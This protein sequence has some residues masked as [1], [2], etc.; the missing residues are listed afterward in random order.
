MVG[1][2]IIL[3]S[4]EIQSSG[5]KF[6]T[7]FINRKRNIRKGFILLWIPFDTYT[8]INLSIQSG[9][10][11]I[12]SIQKVWV[13]SIS[14]LFFP[15]SWTVHQLNK[16]RW[17]IDTNRQNRSSLEWGFSE[18]GTVLD[19]EQIEMCLCCQP[20]YQDTSYQSSGHSLVATVTRKVSGFQFPTISSLHHRLF[21]P[22]EMMGMRAAWS[23]SNLWS[24]YKTKTRPAFNNV[25]PKDWYFVLD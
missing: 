13:K 12:S 18:S 14:K 22:T 7:S 16:S 2:F 15:L 19:W 21:L 11:R 9:G 10:V 24:W 23:S 25:K 3:Y 17:T 1:E 5:G 6:K 4:C 8:G 20:R